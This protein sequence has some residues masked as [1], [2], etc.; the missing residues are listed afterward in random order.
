[1]ADFVVRVFDV[2]QASANLIEFGN[3]SVGVV[4]CGVSA[5][6][7]NPL[8]DRLKQLHSKEALDR[9]AFVVLTHLDFDHI[10]GIA[11]ILEDETLV[12]KMDAIYCNHHPFRLLFEMLARGLNRRSGVH[13][14]PQFY[15]ALVTLRRIRQA[16]QLNDLPLYEIQ[17][18]AATAP[19]DYPAILTPFPGDDAPLRI[20]VLAPTSALVPTAVNRLND[21]LEHDKPVSELMRSLAK[22]QADWN[23]SSIVLRIGSDET[24]YALLPGDATRGTLEE[25]RSRLLD[26]ELDVDFVVAWHHGARLGPKGDQAVDE[27]LWKFAKGDYG[28]LVVGISAGMGNQHGHPHEETTQAIQRIG[29]DYYC[30]QSK[31]G[32]GEIEDI[33]ALGGLDLEPTSVGKVENGWLPD[34]VDSPCCCGTVIA[35]FSSTGLTVE[36]ET[37]RAACNC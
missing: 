4:D 23:T 14:N 17:A 27:A 11:T 6:G 2:G 18:P 10:S 24:G 20:E 34:E 9:I 25:I 1:M 35:S 31:G 13:R 32:C 29:G 3:G 33:P 5:S 37:G 7:E 12:E 36:T 15:G 22:Y 8:Y 19:S 21:L 16:A 30:T 28:S 26:K